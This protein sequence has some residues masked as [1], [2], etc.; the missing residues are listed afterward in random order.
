MRNSRSVEQTVLSSP[1]VARGGIEA[2]A[3]DS[4]RLSSRS[5]RLASVGERPAVSP[6]RLSRLMRASAS[7]SLSRVF[8]EVAGTT[9]VVLPRLAR[10]S[11]SSTS[12][13]RSRVRVVVDGVVV[14]VDVVVDAGGLSNPRIPR[15]T[16]S[17]PSLASWSLP[18]APVV[19]AVCGTLPVAG[20]VS[21]RRT[22]SSSCSRIRR[23]S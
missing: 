13:S 19:V 4:S 12:R 21:T 16:C 10:S 5:L 18:G 11:S 23:R 6:S 7:R 9:R 22:P 20:G 3:A 1:A 8:V 2:A 15:R 17:I 14:S